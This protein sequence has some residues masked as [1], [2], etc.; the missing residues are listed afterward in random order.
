M[1]QN[2]RL[3]EGHD[4]RDLVRNALA[5]N[6]YLTGRDLRVEFEHSDVIIRGA[7]RTWYHKQVAQES[8][9]RID[10]IGAIRNELQVVDA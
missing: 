6:P 8:V 10:G 7:V 1:P 4:L 3:E 9:R 5:R 2:A